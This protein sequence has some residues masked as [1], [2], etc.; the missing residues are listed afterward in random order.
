LFPSRA[1]AIVSGLFGLLALLLAAVGVY[2]IT[3]YMVG[4]RTREVGIRIAL[5]AD[6]R[7]ILRLIVGQGVRVTFVG[8]GVGLGAAL[9]LT[10]F[11]SG[12]LFGVSPFDP[13]T[14][15]AVALLLTFVALIACYIPA[16]RAT[17][18]DPMIALKYE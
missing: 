10:R 16:R 15:V 13:L 5:G 17:K 4:Q 6:R 18:I 11:L 9:S 3:A 7:D 1:M 2:G 14:F 12:Q 8:G